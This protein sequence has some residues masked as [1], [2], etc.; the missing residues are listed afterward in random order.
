[1]STINDIINHVELMTHQTIIRDQ[2][3]KGKLEIVG[4]LGIFG[5]MRKISVGLL[6]SLLAIVGCDRG[7]NVATH[8]GTITKIYDL[9]GKTVLPG[10]IDVEI[11]VGE[12]QA[13]II[14]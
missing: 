8:I 6:V 7:D 12:L 3:S 10:L 5:S 13:N 2:W 14:R 1:M 4:A 11:V 9:E